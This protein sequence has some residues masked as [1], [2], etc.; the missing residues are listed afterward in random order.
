[1]EETA[2]ITSTFFHKETNKLESLKNVI[3]IYDYVNSK[4]DK[5]TIKVKGTRRKLDRL[6]NQK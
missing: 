6:S 2:S 5:R 4:N 3:K 1:M